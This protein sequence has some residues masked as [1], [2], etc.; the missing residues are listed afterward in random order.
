MNYYNKE[1]DRISKVYFSNKD[2]IHLAVAT[3]KH[4]DCHYSNALNLELLARLQLTS[5]YHLLRVF[6]KYH[7]ITPRQY[8]IQKRI[9]KAKCMLRTGKSVTETCYSVGFESIHSFSKLFKNKIG[10][11]P[12]TYRKAIFDKSKKQKE[13]TL[14]F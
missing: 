14:P 5:K 12:S 6:K 11:P 8:L 9:S 2:Q 10:V 1:I 4:L 3:K 7:G 13:F